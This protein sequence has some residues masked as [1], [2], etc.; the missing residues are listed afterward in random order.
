[1]FSNI[2]VLH[3]EKNSTIQKGIQLL[4]TDLKN[5]ADDISQNRFLNMMQFNFSKE[6]PLNTIFIAGL[7]CHVA[8][9]LTYA[10]DNEF[11]KPLTLIHYD[12]SAL[13]GNYLPTGPL[14]N[15]KEQNNKLVVLGDPLERAV[16]TGIR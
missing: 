11:L 9:F 12:P 2:L 14:I 1:M 15:S 4:H 13:S 10:E 6:T 3:Q 16:P 5:L 8:V 7:L